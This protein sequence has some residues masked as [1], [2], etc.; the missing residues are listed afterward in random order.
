[1]LF[2]FDYDDKKFLIDLE[3]FD[4]GKDKTEVF[5]IKYSDEPDD[6]D[7]YEIKMYQVEGEYLTPIKVTEL[8]RSF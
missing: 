1:M 2:E 7:E 4:H 5:A 6:A 3:H 8:Q